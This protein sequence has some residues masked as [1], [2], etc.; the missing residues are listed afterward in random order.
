VICTS[1]RLRSD[2][3]RQ[4][5]ALRVAPACGV[6]VVP[7]GDFLRGV[8]RLGKGATIPCASRLAA[9]RMPGQRNPPNEGERALV[10]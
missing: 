7:Q 9:A 2:A 5:L 10:K 4:P 1:D 8:A 3:P 6:C